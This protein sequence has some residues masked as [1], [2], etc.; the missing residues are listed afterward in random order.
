[1]TALSR[2]HS[3]VAP[4]MLLALGC[5]VCNIPWMA[6]IERPLVGSL[7]YAAG[8]VMALW[9][10]VDMYRMADDRD[11]LLATLWTALLTF[12]A[13]SIY[14]IA[15]ASA[16]L[17]ASSGMLALEAVHAFRADAVLI[18]SLVQAAV[19]LTNVVFA[20]KALRDAF[21]LRS[22]EKT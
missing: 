15:T 10:I 17:I 13:S 6:G 2:P 8:C 3:P 16:W 19:W 5:L 1:M 4:L 12:R 7:L 20:G 18:W 21:R 22:S 14:P 9:A 11:G